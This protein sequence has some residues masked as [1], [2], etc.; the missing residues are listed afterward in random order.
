M[1]VDKATRKARHEGAISP[2]LNNV[3]YA[4][5]KSGGE[6]QVTFREEAGKVKQMVKKNGS[7]RE[8]G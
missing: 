5:Q 4:D 6:G 8:V 7:W 2:N 3:N 1:P